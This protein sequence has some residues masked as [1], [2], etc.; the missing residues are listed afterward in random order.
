MTIAALYDI[1][2]NYPALQAV[3]NELDKRLIDQL[4]IGGDVLLGPMPVACLE[5]LFSLAV[6]TT[7]IMGNC[8]EAVLN[9]SLGRSIRALPERVLADIE[10]TA[11]QVEKF[12]P[13]LESWK[14]SITIKHPV[15]GGILFCHATPRSNDEIF[16]TNTDLDKVRQLLAPVDADFVVCGHTHIQFDNQVDDKRIIN[17]G[18]VGMP[19]GSP[20]AYWILIGDQVELKRTD[21]DYDK[22]AKQVRQSDYP[23]ARDFAD[24]NILNP[25]SPDF[26]LNIFRQQ[27]LEI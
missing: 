24:K 3:L 6:P 27:E 22:A 15:W 16:T 1:H 11:G 18:S 12:I 17:A 10:W 21:Y 23:F 7:F 2:G 25:P 9:F 20:G 5:R 14:S 4:V 19:F 26:M 8:D 13:Q